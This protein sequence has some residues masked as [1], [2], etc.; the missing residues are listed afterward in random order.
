MWDDWAFFISVNDFSKCVQPCC[1]THHDM[2][3]IRDIKHKL[4]DL[5]LFI[6]VGKFY[7][8]V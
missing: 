7:I 3:I 5:R 1:N 8:A 2:P 6:E 4:K